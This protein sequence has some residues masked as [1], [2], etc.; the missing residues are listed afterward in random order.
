[1]RQIGDGSAPDL[2]AV[3]VALT[4]EHG[5]WRGAVRNDGAIHARIASHDAAPCQVISYIYMP[6]QIESSPHFLDPVY[7]VGDFAL[8]VRP[9]VHRDGLDRPVW[10][11]RLVE[12]ARGFIACEDIFWVM[13]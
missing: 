9:N 8:E 3:A 12:D 11:H 6:T 1:M 10:T 4:Q 13:T 7:S 5:G 2:V